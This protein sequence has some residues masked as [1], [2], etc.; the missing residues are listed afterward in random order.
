[1]YFKKMGRVESKL[2]VDKGD[3]IKKIKAVLKVLKF[4]VII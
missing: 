1:M 3:L 2:L 4:E